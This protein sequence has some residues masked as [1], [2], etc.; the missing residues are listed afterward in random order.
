MVGAGLPTRPPGSS[1]SDPDRLP[2]IDQ[3]GAT[4]NRVGSQR[5]TTGPE[6]PK[7]GP[8]KGF[9]SLKKQPSSLHQRRRGG[10]AIPKPETCAVSTRGVCVVPQDVQVARR[11]QVLH[12]LRQH[13]VTHLDAVLVDHLVH[14]LQNN[15][16]T[17]LKNNQTRQP[18]LQI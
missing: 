15:A 14:D 1:R 7:T 8:Q 5:P 9:S 12:G 6:R 13:L 16:V 17:A 4:L 3:Q 11:R 2:H 18:V 10:Q